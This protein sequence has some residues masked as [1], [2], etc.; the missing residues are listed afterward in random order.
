ML[1]VATDGRRRA[2]R[3]PSSSRRSCL[4]ARILDGDVLQAVEPALAPDIG[5]C[6][7]DIGYPVTPGAATYAF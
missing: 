3:R 4:R 1:F 7:V 6:A 2:A 5:A